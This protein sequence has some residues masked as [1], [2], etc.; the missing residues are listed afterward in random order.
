M[1]GEQHYDEF[2][3]YIG[4][5]IDSSS[6][7]EEEEEE[8][9]VVVEASNNVDS[10]EEME[11][12][13][14]VVESD[15][16]VLHEDKKY[17]PD[18]DE[19][20]GDVQVLV[21]DEDTQGIEEPIIKPI[22][23]KSFSLLEEKPLDLKCSLKFTA[24]LMS[25]PGLVRN[26]ALIGHLHHGKTSFCDVL[27]GNTLENGWDILNDDIRFT[28]TRNDERSR[29]I[30]IKSCPVSL[31]LEDGRGKTYLVNVIDCPGHVGFSDEMT[32]GLQ[33]SDGAVLVVDAVEGVMINTK[34]AVKSALRAQVPIM[35]CISKVDRLIHELK[36]P[37]Q[38]AYHKLALVIDQVNKVIVSHGGRPVC[39]KEGTVC[40]ASGTN[41]WC[42]TLESFSR[43]YLSRR[44]SRGISAKSFS[45]R[46][47]GDVCFDAP[48]KTFK[49]KGDTSNKVR[50]FVQ[51]VLEPLYKLYAQVLGEEP[52][53]L[54]VTLKKVGVKLTNDELRLDPRP[55][56]RLVMSRFF[57]TQGVSGFVDMICAHV[58][59]PGQPEGAHKLTNI[60][61]GSNDDTIFKQ[62]VTSDGDG[63]LMINVVKMYASPD[64]K[65]FSAF[66]KV[67]SGTIK[68]GDSVKILGESYS[69]DDQEDMATGVAKRLYMCHARHRLEV[70]RV[71]AGN[72]VLIDGLENLIAKTA[73]I[74]GVDNENPGTFSPLHFGTES[75]FKLALEPLNPP[76][77]PKMLHGLRCV[78][79]SYPLLRTKVEESGE[80]VIF[81]TGE[82]YM[83]CVMH[84][85]RE[86]FSG[87][88][89]KVS[90]PSV[91]FNET[92][93]ETSVLKS[94]AE[95]PNKK[96]K[97]TMISQPLEKGMGDDIER[98]DICIDWTPKRL[99]SH[100]Q[101]KYDWD[102]LAARSLWA[103]GPVS[104]GPNVF[105]NDTLPG[106]VDT[107]LLGKVKGS[108][109]QGFRWASREGPLCD[110]PMRNVKFRLLDVDIASE[111]LHRGAGYVI[112]TARRVCY[113]S[114]LTATPRLMEPIYQL[115]VQGTGDM[116]GAINKVL[117]RRRGHITNDTSVPGTPFS[118]YHGYIPVIDSF[119]FETDLRQLTQGQAYVHQVFDHWGIVPGN[120]LDS[121][122]TLRPLEPSTERELAREFMMKTRRRKGLPEE[123]SI[124]KYF[125]D[126]E[127]LKLYYR[128]QS[129]QDDDSDS[130]SN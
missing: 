84:D 86:M 36:I 73:T 51:F 109:V 32:A 65:T 35:L 106:E 127:L 119:G 49:K 75:V 125:D 26:V 38:D 47:W 30:S 117:R 111:A 121:S 48:S 94:Y 62:M 64:A 28:D 17:Y 39:P 52:A 41:N 25:R 4:P 108:I 66:G 43:L 120:P 23:M 3:N 13:G 85:L 45:K 130:T 50:S 8:E 14:R 29:E 68:T 95:T 71:P 1:D 103:F 6:S 102:K 105:L 78:S 81:G 53:K 24:S 72:W 19:V 58:P 114:F 115:E 91:S 9:Q 18:A 88:E 67:Y 12:V 20:Y 107:G 5:D 118:L 96:N 11:Q 70:D 2:G 97:F 57:Q 101:E 113:S 34:R 55:L 61:R 31:A 27:I 15:A 60:Y 80:H 116:R 44:K 124:N 46:L 54:R 126:P 83:D 16:I 79:K 40:F 42:F 129:Q 123:V 59:A 37:P 112:P 90:D 93:V 99:S 22:K 10:D 7:S 69:A 74:T 33:A 82:L 56:L 128:Q 98:G 89:I 87:I 104:N 21:E 110:E 77:L 92:V 63:D 100:L 122:I 76:E